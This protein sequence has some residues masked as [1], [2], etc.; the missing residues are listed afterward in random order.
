MCSF[1]I[2]VTIA[3][4]AGT[5]FSGQIV[6]TGQDKARPNFDPTITEQ[7][8]TGCINDAHA[9]IVSAVK[10]MVAG[11]SPDAEG[12]GEAA[13]NRKQLFLGLVG[14]GL[15]VAWLMFPFPG[16]PPTPFP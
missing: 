8:K 5:V 4:P 12:C 7:L 16:G 3:V 10:L 1:S 6:N 9:L 2:S 13:Q 11:H 14:G 15:L